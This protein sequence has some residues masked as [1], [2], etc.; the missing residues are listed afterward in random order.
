MTTGQITIVFENNSKI[1]KI[2]IVGQLPRRGA[3]KVQYYLTK[4]LRANAGLARKAARAQA[5]ENIRLRAIKEREQAEVNAEKEVVEDV[6]KMFDNAMPE[7]TGPL[8]HLAGIAPENKE[9]PEEEAILTLEDED[10]L[11][12]EDGQ[13]GTVELTEGSRSTEGTAEG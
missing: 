8:N 11:D 4:A 6:Q 2:D 5:A 13:E 7:P 12:A 1:P 3:E 10:T 9:A